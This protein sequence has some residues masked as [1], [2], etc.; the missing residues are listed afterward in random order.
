[1]RFFLFRFFARRRSTSRP[2]EIGKV[3]QIGQTKING[4]V[5]ETSS[6][7]KVSIEFFDLT[8][9]RVRVALNGV[10]EPDFSYAIDRSQR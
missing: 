2:A 6:Q 8:V 10:F 7:A 4:V 9:V 3:T 5:L 1:M